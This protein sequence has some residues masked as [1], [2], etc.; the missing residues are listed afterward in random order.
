MNMTK[1][2]Q[3]LIMTLLENGFTLRASSGCITIVATNNPTDLGLLQ[4]LLNT[5]VLCKMLVKQFRMLPKKT[6]TKISLSGCSRFK[7]IFRF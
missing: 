5:S 6:Q 4:N 7:T 2:K 3:L 1:K